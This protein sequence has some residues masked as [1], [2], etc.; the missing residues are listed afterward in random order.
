MV[1]ETRKT[2][3]DEIYEAL[4]QI[5]QA[6]TQGRVEQ[7]ADYF[8]EGMV[9][10]HTDFQGRTTGKA[11]CVKS[12]KEF[13]CRAILH[14]YNEEAPTIDVWNDTAI[15]SYRFE[16]DYEM[17]GERFRESGHDLFTFV[18]Q[19]GRW[20]AVWRAMTAR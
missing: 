6:W 3:H 11:A 7:L 8:H 1:A 19:G 20:L 5:N 16:I 12:Y 17:D 14:A 2:S 4:K 10:V 9:I 15:C 13:T 18:R